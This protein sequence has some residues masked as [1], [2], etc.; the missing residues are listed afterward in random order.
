M[1]QPMDEKEALLNLAGSYMEASKRAIIGEIACE[2]VRTYL[3]LA[4]NTTTFEEARDRILYL[5]PPMSE[6]AQ[7]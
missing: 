5:L 7:A 3:L 6:K 4:S 2:S 1:S